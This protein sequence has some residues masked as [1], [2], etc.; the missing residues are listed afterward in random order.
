MA[1]KR[2]IELNGKTIKAKT[3]CGA[4][5]A[6]LNFNEGELYEI[7]TELGKSGNCVKNMLHLISILYSIILQSEME[8]TEKKD[9]IK[10]HCLG[11]SCGFP[12]EFQ[13]KKYLS[14]LDFLGQIILKELKDGS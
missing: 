13:N 9:S 7:R 4:F 10:K 2:P 11:V 8:Q 12:F 5:Y 6:T 1:K 14:C 3:E